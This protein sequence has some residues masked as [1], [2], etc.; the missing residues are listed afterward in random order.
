MGAVSGQGTTDRISVK[1][2]QSFRP[3]MERA[4]LTG[5]QVMTQPDKCVTG[6]EVLRFAFAPG[7]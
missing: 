4:G 1:A 2:M 6:L 3:I 7:F 5:R